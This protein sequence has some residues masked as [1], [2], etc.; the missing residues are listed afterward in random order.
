MPRD[1]E[2]ETRLTMDGE[3]DAL[4]SLHLRFASA[5]SFK[6]AVPGPVPVS[7]F[8]QTRRT[9]IPVLGFYFR[10]NPLK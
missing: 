6:L 7:L 10:N 8:Y 3:R 4:S 2:S 5:A 9:G 1:R